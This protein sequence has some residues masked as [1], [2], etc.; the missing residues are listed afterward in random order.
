MTLVK[1]SLTQENNYI[2]LSY[3]R[4]F[5]LHVFQKK[6]PPV[7]QQL[8]LQ[9]PIAIPVHRAVLFSISNGS[10]PVI[11]DLFHLDRFQMIEGRSDAL[12]NMSSHSLTKDLKGVRIWYNRTIT[13]A[14]IFFRKF[15]YVASR[16]QVHLLVVLAPVP[17][18]RDVPY[19]DTASYPIQMQHC[20]AI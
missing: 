6:P 16:I 14:S 3:I 7:R 17:S 15:L 13:I 11:R 12:G 5:L 2:I 19:G 20:T 10:F 1:Y 18:G 9:V 4:D 8:F